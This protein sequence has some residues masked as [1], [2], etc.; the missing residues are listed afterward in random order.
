MP[1]SLSILQSTQ[2]HPSQIYQQFINKVFP[3]NDM[4]KKCLDTG[5]QWLEQYI[6]PKSK[7]KKNN[8]RKTL[9]SK[10]IYAVIYCDRS[11][12]FPKKE[13]TEK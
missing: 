9:H 3:L 6:N 5:E 11:M 8:N 1:T 12:T 10:E 4:D 7:G 2:I 13:R